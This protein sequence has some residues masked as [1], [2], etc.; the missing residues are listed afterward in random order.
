LLPA[1]RFE[2]EQMYWISA[3]IQVATACVGG[4]EGMG[5]C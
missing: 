4:I 5:R 1:Y 3:L 2:V